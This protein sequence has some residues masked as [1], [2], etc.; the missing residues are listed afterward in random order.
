[1]A[2]VDLSFRC[3]VCNG[4]AEVFRNPN[5]LEST[6]RHL[7]SQMV[8]SD[9]GHMTLGFAGVHKL[10]TSWLTQAHET[11]RKV[12]LSGMSWVPACVGPEC[13][14]TGPGIENCASWGVC[15]IEEMARR[16]AKSGD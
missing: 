12:P 11:T 1:M 9:M 13:V 4:P 3:P 10:L 7:D 5:G 16:A 15:T 14:Y 2:K 8:L 6:Y